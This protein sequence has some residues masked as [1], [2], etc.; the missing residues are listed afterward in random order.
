MSHDIV[1]FKNSLLGNVFGKIPKSKTPE[2]IDF[3]GFPRFFPE[4][5]QK[6]EFQKCFWENE[7]LVFGR[8]SVFGNHFWENLCFWGGMKIATKYRRCAYAK[9]GL[10]REMSKDIVK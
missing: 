6:W 2:T 10:Q 7:K 5:F 4:I 3:T 8:N 9:K 1:F